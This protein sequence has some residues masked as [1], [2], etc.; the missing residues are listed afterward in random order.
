MRLQSAAGVLLGLA[1]LRMDSSQGVRAASFAS[2]GGA[3]STAAPMNEARQ[4]VCTA[5]VG[6]RIYVAGGFRVGGSTANTVEVYDVDTGAWSFVAPLPQA[7]NHC[8]A[9]AVGGRVYVTGG[10]LA[11]GGATAATWEYNPA[12]NSWTGKAPMPTA[13]GAGMA[14]VVGRRIYVAGGSPGGNAFA[15]YDAATNLWTTLPPLPTPR[16][17]LAGGIANRRLFAVGGR[18]PLTLDVLEIFHLVTGTWST[19]APM[20]T[21]RSGH[22]AAVV[23]GCL[24]T[25]GGEG[26][27]AHPSGVF[28]ETESYDPVTNTWDSLAPLPTPRH[29][30][31]AA[32]VD[33]R[34]HV[35]G[36]ATVQGFGA[37]AVHEV[38]TP[39]AAASCP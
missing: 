7:V 36:G 14:A 24:Y 39:P 13:R 22:A 19:G 6:R 4:E 11:G 35:P 18:P 1:A 32:V 15:V 31:G 28:P 34:I 12:T 2:G 38:F 21:G 8:M 3:W 5:A 29:G 30:M 17:H 23:A 33:G 20:P 10:A 27:A 9:A 16:D 26:N 37:V 25:F